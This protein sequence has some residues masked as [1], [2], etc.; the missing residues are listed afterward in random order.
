MR[1]PALR[2]R[3]GVGGGSRR[4]MWSSETLPYS[5]KGDAWHSLT[6]INALTKASS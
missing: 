6:H 3:E 1:K 5:L 4:R 2:S